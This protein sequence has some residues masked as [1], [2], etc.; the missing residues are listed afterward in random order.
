VPELVGEYHGGRLPIEDIIDARKQIRG[1]NQQP[2][3]HSQCRNCELLSYQHWPAKSYPIDIIN[4]SHFEKCNLKCTYCLFVRSDYKPSRFHANLLPMVEEVIRQGYLSPKAYILWGGGE[5]T[6]LSEFAEMFEV[7]CHHGAR[8]YVATNG[9]LL[10]ETLL[11]WLP[12]R[13]VEVVVSV[14][15][16]LRATYRMIKQVDAFDAVWKHIAAYAKAGGDKAC[17]KIILTRQN[18]NEIPE[19][20]DKVAQAGVRWVMADVDI[21]NPV[22]EPDIVEAAGLL[23]IECLRRGIEFGAGAGGALSHPENRFRLKVQ[24]ARRARLMAL[25]RWEQAHFI[26]GVLKRLQSYWRE[27]GTVNTARLAIDFVRQVYADW[28]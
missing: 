9:V 5:V 8:H 10:S 28:K 16:G 20:M 4:F 22:L 11:K 17:A 23:G 26:P 6:L 25:S 18:V 15:A 12:R 19:F 2:E 21:G 1:E 24:D 3:R 27:Q 7:L 13:N 14:D